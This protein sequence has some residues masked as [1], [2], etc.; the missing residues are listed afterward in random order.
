MSERRACRAIGC[1]RVTMRYRTDRAEDANLGQ[2]MRAIAQGHRRFGYW[3][4]H[5]P[6]QAGAVSDQPQETL[7]TL[8]GREADAAPPR[9]PQEGDRD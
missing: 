3:L 5:F 6:A 8:S 7:P 9:R 4:P 2:R 1:C